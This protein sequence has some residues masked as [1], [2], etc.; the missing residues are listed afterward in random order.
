MDTVLTSP[1]VFTNDFV[2]YWILMMLLAFV[3]YISGHENAF[4]KKFHTI[5]P[6]KSPVINETFSQTNSSI[7]E[8]LDYFNRF[9]SIINFLWI[10][11]LNHHLFLLM[12]L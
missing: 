4:G 9:V 5:Y 11:F 10:Q 2:N 7:A 1:L 12:I 8:Y 3:F 6:S